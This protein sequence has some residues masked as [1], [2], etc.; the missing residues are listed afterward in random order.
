MVA[1]CEGTLRAGQSMSDANAVPEGCS[2]HP[3]FDVKSG[4]MAVHCLQDAKD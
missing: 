4:N 1:H 2:K 3:T